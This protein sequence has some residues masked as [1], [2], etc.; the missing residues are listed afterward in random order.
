MSTR[1]PFLSRRHLTDGGRNSY[2]KDGSF[3]QKRNPLMADQQASHEERSIGSVNKEVRHEA[4]VV[5]LL[6]P[7]EKG[8]HHQQGLHH[9]RA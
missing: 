5:S 1:C 9:A 7:Q 4:K 3:H 6:H 8:L 2:S